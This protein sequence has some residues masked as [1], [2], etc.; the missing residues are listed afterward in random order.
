[1]YT[2]LAQDLCPPFLS[3]DPLPNGS[4]PGRHRCENRSKSTIP[5]F[6]KIGNSLFQKIG[7]PDK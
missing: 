5:A 2:D 4:D 3:A 7:I 6:L 1:M